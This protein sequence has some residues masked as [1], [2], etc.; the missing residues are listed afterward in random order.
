QTQLALKVPFE[1]APPTDLD[2]VA[3]A[4]SARGELLSS[5]A[6]KSGA[7]N[8]KLDPDHAVRAR[9]LI[10][11]RLPEHRAKEEPT[12]ERLQRLGA[13]EA[14]GANAT[15]SEIPERIWRSWLWCR[16]LI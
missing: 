8:L 9:V 5:S 15:L 2:T 7:A 13:F 16:C 1:G 12:L 3:Y 6:I 11:P 10:G 4:F 14:Y